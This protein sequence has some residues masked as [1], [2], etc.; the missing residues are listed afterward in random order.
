MK[1]TARNYIVSLMKGSLE[2]I[3]PLFKYK[4]SI[5]QLGVIQNNERLSKYVI[6][7]TYRPRE[8][9]IN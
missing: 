1:L 8:I 7:Y 6:E 2:L 9:L 3:L 5:Q 4:S